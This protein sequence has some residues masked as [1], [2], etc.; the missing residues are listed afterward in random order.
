MKGY[1][2]YK[3]FRKE[4]LKDPAFKKAYDEL[5]PEFALISLMIKKRLKAGLTQR[6][7]ALKIGTKQP[8]ISRLEQGTFNPTVKF[9]NRVA[10]ALDGK[11][12]I[13]IT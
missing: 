12:K 3:V 7:L 9:L 13:T 11:L 6:D 5:E 2:N 8:V 10:K 1:R 4:L